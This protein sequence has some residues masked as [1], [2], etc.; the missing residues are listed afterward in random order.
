MASAKQIHQAK[1]V[2]STTDGTTWVTIA[3]Y[4]LTSNATAQIETWLVG[5]DSTGKV[6]SA[7]SVQAFERIGGVAV[8]VGSLVDLLTFAAGSNALLTSCACRI[9]LS[10]DDI[11]LQVKGITL[12]TIEWMGKI[13]IRIN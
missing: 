4:T 3:T 2:S 10:G 7:K 5:K 13:E 8:L 11:Q 9:N 1:G 12:T 6:A